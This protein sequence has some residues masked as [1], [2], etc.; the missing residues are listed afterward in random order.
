MKPAGLRKL[1]KRQI[2]EKQIY[3]AILVLEE[4][5]DPVSALTLAGA[6][7]EILGNMLRDK[8][9]KC[10]FEAKVE[11]D[12]ELWAFAKKR[13]GATGYS[14]DV[15]EEKEIK[16]NSNRIRNS[17]KHK[18]DG[19][20]VETDYNYQAEEMIARAISNYRVLY[21]GKA[22]SQKR[23]ARWFEDYVQ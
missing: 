22:P 6:S 10:A 14:L 23:V 2:A 9:L 3:R 4:Q 15:P 8:G 21:S 18:M 5:D 19:R 1:S 12:K 17:L 13:A 11:F 7:E 16:N 20:P